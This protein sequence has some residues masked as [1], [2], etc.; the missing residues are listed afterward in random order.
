MVNLT[1]DTPTI[2]PF[3][4]VVE[5]LALARVGQVKADSVRRNAGPSS[6]APCDLALLDLLDT[7][8]PGW[9]DVTVLDPRAR[10]M[11]AQPL[12]TAWALWLDAEALDAGV[13]DEP[14]LDEDADLATVA[15]FLS[16]G[17]PWLEG[18]DHEAAHLLH[19]TVK[20]LVRDLAALT[21]DAVDYRR[22]PRSTCPTCQWRMVE[23]TSGWECPA[24]GDEVLLHVELEKAASAYSPTFTLEEAAAEVGTSYPTLRRWVHAGL[25]PTSGKRGRAHLLD[26]DGLAA[27]RL[28]ATA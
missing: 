17:W 26:H 20:T 13:Y 19:L 24:C 21:G 16:M 23:T 5:L 3:G 12:M 8:S 1:T 11:G 22:P 10:T 2:P 27:A 25:I 18:Q 9:V 7:R 15:D 14:Q 6:M 4:A 28:L